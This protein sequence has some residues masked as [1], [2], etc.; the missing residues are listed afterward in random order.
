MPMLISYIPLIDNL[1]RDEIA[2]LE[3][4]ATKSDGGRW[5]IPDLF[6]WC[7]VVTLR[8]NSVC[9]APD[10]IVGDPRKLSQ[11]EQ[12]FFDADPATNVHLVFRDRLLGRNRSDTA[13]QRIVDFLRQEVVEK[14]FARRQQEQAH[15]TPA[16]PYAVDEESDYVDRVLAFVENNRLADG[17]VNY[18]E[19]A[20]CFYGMLFAA[21]TNTFAAMAWSVLQ[22]LYHPECLAKLIDEQRRVLPNGGQADEVPTLEQLDRM[23]YLQACV[24][25]TTRLFISGVAF[26]KVSN[27]DGVSFDN[28]RVFLPHGRLVALLSKTVH[29]ESAIFSDP[30]RFDPERLLPPRSEDKRAKHA[31]LVFGGGP[32]MCL[33]KRFVLIELKIFLSTLVRT[34]ALQLAQPDRQPATDKRQVV[35]VLRPTEPVVLHGRALS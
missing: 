9:F 28:G 2:M 33:G 22:L 29:Q 10:E 17:S 32:H 6:K 13:F 5:T 35:F 34:C 3:K 1:I 16:Q 27:V 19:I 25:E 18:R 20:F 14:R 8:L 26:R 4:S 31:L 21:Q 12:L 30:A 7:N 11:W 24:M 23:E 15:W